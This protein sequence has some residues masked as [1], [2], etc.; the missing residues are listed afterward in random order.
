MVD[1]YRY[2][3]YLTKG[4]RKRVTT[5]PV[6]HHTASMLGGLLALAVAIT[7]A[8]ALLHIKISSVQYNQTSL[9]S[10]QDFNPGRRLPTKYWNTTDESQDYAA[11]SITP[12]GSGARVS[13]SNATEAYRILG[14][15][16]DHSLVRLAD[17]GQTA[18]ITMPESPAGVSYTAQ[19]YASS[20]ICKTI[21][22]LCDPHSNGDG[23]TAC[24]SW[25][26]NCTV[27]TAGVSMS[28]N[29]SG[30]GSPFTSDLLSNLDMSFYNVSSKATNTSGSG[31]KSAFNGQ[32]WSAAVFKLLNT[33][34]TDDRVLINTTEMCINLAGHR[35]LASCDLDPPKWS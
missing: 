11:C 23:C 20:T 7:I 24:Q 15:A 28:G 10:N 8:D 35:R 9:Y 19:S 18:V 25:A 21:T 2:L 22:S 4:K 29:Y 31:V 6:L 14:N 33:E 13:F 3:Q 30:I 16:S 1:L 17:D 34:I 5:P 32:V 26:Y 27:P 12:G